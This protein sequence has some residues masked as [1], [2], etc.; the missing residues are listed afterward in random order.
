[1]LCLKVTRVAFGADDSEYYLSV[2][3]AECQKLDLHLNDCSTLGPPTRL[4]V[5]TPTSISI[6]ASSASRHHCVTACKCNLCN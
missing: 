1:M 3:C 4:L 5:A 2:E 6:I